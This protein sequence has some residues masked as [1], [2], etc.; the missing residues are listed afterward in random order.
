MTPEEIAE[1]IIPQPYFLGLTVKQ[2]SDLKVAIVT[3]LRN[4]RNEALEEAAVLVETHAVA[5]PLPSRYGLVL[6][7]TPS[8]TST[9]FAMA[10]RALK[11]KE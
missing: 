1:N 10:L 9:G 7:K 3:A 2:S 4:A 6:R 8:L 5:K 11:H